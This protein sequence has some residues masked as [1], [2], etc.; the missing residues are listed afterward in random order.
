MVPPS[1]QRIDKFDV[2]RRLGRGGMGSVYLARDPDIDRLVAIKLLHEGFDSDELRGRF[3]REA[4]SASGLRH[5]NIVTI[6]Q[7]GTFLE[8]PFIVMEYIEGETF[9]DI[10][11]SRGAAP[12]EQK[13]QLFDQL[14][15][16]LQYA[17]AKGVVH[18]DIKPSNVMVDSEG[19]VRILDFGIARLGDGGLTRTG[20]VLGTINYMSP[21][22]L[23]G[24][25]VDAR[26]DIFSAGLVGYELLTSKQAFGQSFPEILRHIGFQD[27][28]PIEELSPGIDPSL[29]RVINRCL[30]KQAD[31]RYADCSAIR[32]DLDVVRQAMARSVQDA[33]VPV[34]EPVPSVAPAP[35]TSPTLVI[36]RRSPSSRGGA[37]ASVQPAAPPRTRPLTLAAVAVVVLIVAAGAWRVMSPVNQSSDSA[38]TLPAP[39]SP[40]AAAPAVTVAPP[41]QA[42][43][44]EAQGRAPAPAAAISGDPSPGDL[45]RSQAA[46]AW[47]RGD[48]EIALASLA[49]AGPLGP[50][51]AN[52][53][54][55]AEFVASARDRATGAR[56][57]AV[58][59]NGR[60]TAAFAAGDARVSEGDRLA[61]QSQSADAVRAYV[62]AARRFQEA[63]KATPPPAPVRVG[64]AVNAPKLI[65]R[66]SPEY[67]AAAL[68]S[69]VQGVVVLEATIGIDGK[70]SDV[71]ITRSIP[72]LDSAAADAVRQWLYEP[73]VVN[74]ARVPV[75][76]SVAV[77]FKLTAP[78]PIRVGGDIKPPT[79]TKRVTPPYPPEAQAAGVQGIVIMEAT[80]GVDGKVT[81]VRVLRSIPLLDQAAMDA[82][83]QFEYTSTIVNG[84]AVPVLMTVTVNFT[85]TPPAAERQASP[86]STGK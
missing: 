43:S 13:L 1:V 25:V 6:F 27:P 34:T 23:A 51:E 67:P 45:L 75:I 72:A 83:R 8:R 40:P 19:V 69:R 65:S 4:R 36:P 58:S 54:L 37:R 71:R 39:Q 22:Q 24:Q 77:E 44:P 11:A 15:A 49:A 5:T 12:I 10:I 84:V 46:D 48:V 7:T 17:H 29:V 32:R 82:V 47:K 60:G 81:D 2:L 42:P 55:L 63:T 74:G 33:A 64:G 56:R 57:S 50:V 78:Q 18:R 66:V 41:V 9:A 20:V 76:I 68:S 28:Q 62:D 86:P 3:N 79:Q 35:V 85:L 30:A 52:N 16:G 61:K 38:R 59:V 53:R 70:I 14:L 73:T 31:E 26:A 80:I 21:E